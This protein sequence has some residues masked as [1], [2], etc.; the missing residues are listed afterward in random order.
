MSAV[1]LGKFIANLRNEKGLTQE[2]LAEILY[3]DKKKVSRWECGRSTPEFE[4]LIKLS[5]ILDV[6]LYELS[7]CQK[8]PK[9]KLNDKLLNK[10]KSI[11]DLKKYNARKIIKMILLTIILI[12]FLF[13]TIY[14]IKYYGTDEVYEFESLDDN[15]TIEGNYIVTKD[16]SIVNISSIKDNINKSN[17]FTESDKCDFEIN[18]DDIRLF[19]YKNSNISIIN[20]T[21][22]YDEKGIIK[23]NKNIFTFHSKCYSNQKTKKE[24]SISFKLAKKYSNKIL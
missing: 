22:N 24:Y 3:I 17:I 20:H 16:F 10:F 14:T 12:L 7:I 11:K 4:L 5:E 19:Y 15:Y 1:E 21:I 23:N 8:I 6:S 18:N 2:E 13:T 9:E